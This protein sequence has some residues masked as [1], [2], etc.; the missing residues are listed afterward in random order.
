MTMFKLTTLG[1]LTALTMPL[2]ACDD[3]DGDDEGKGD[4][5]TSGSAEDGGEAETG[6]PGDGS[7][8][9]GAPDDDGAPGDGGDD[10]GGDEGFPQDSGFPGDTGFPGDGSEDSGGGG[11]AGVGDTCEGP[12]DCPTG[13]CIVAGDADFGFCSI[14]CGS[15]S[16]CPSFW[17]CEEVGNASLTYCVPG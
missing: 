13:I 16:D 2:T 8:G 12:G 1:F 6:S 11:D 4:D 17:E 15:F 14:E 3:E 5:A 10:A 9:D 7:P